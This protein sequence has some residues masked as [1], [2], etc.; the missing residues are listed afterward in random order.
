VRV[1][2]PL[3][4]TVVFDLKEAHSNKRDSPLS[5]RTILI[6]KILIRKVSRSLK[7]QIWFGDPIQAVGNA[8]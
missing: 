8:V 2:T 1:D 5:S 3:K 7:D 6:K 4:V